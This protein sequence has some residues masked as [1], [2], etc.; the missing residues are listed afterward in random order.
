[1]SDGLIKPS[2]IIRLGMSIGWAT[3][4]TFLRITI[5][6]IHIVKERRFQFNQTGNSNPVIAVS[7]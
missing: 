1:M 2:E 7:N 5:K 6:M 3:K 4:P